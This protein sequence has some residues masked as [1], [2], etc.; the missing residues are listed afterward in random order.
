MIERGAGAVIVS[1]IPPFNNNADEIVRLAERHKIPAM[2]PDRAYMLR[3]GLM[4]Y[5]PDLQEGFQIAVGFV[6][7]ILRW[8]ARPQ[9]RGPAALSGS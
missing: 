6:G 5:T 8:D 1:A 4:S 3:G 9:P 2:Y 7:E